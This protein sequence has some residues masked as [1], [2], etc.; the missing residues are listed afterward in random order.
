MKM[1]EKM[2]TEMLVSTYKTTK[3]HE[4]EN[5]YMNTRYHLELHEWIWQLLYKFNL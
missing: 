3:C 5:R 1:E 4:S 2:S